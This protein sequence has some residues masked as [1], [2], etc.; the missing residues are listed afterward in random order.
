MV[1]PQYLSRAPIKE[2]LI[3]FQFEAPVAMAALEE[4][5]KQIGDQYEKVSL[6]RRQRI[7]INLT[8]GKGTQSEDVNL[9]PVGMRF[10]SPKSGPPH[11]VLTRTSGFTYSR[12]EPYKDWEQ[13]RESAMAVWQRFLEVV[14][15]EVINRVAVRY[16]NALHLPLKEG[17]PFSYY[18]SAAPEIPE[19]LPQAMSA[20]IQ[21]V[22][23]IDHKTSNRAIVTQALEE[24]QA[25]RTSEGVAMFLDIDT[26]RTKQ[27]AAA[28][29]E[30]W[31]ALDSLRDFKNSIFFEHIKEATVE[32]YK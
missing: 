29:A 22:V 7:E 10:E 23:M 32:L 18:L 15:P 2:G 26:F 8:D 20:F 5:A 27:F 12:L 17:Q 3:D 25:A 11:V 31:E 13:L 6:I 21:R 14:Q 9:P 16:I 30:L 24:S 19:K 1:A 4:F 28:D